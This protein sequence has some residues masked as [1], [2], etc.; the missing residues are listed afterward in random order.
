MEQRRAS[1]TTADLGLDEFTSA[2]LHTSQAFSHE[3]EG[4]LGDSPEAIAHDAAII[5][6]IAAGLCD[7]H[8]ERSKSTEKPVPKPVVRDS[9]HEEA[10]SSQQRAES[11]GGTPELGSG[12]AGRPENGQKGAGNSGGKKKNKKKARKSI[13]IENIT[14]RGIG[15]SGGATAAPEDPSVLAPAE[16]N[17]DADTEQ[18]PTDNTAPAAQAGAGEQKQEEE[19][20]KSPLPLEVPL[21]SFPELMRGLEMSTTDPEQLEKMDTEAEHHTPSEHEAEEE[22]DFQDVGSG[23][24]SVGSVRSARGRRLGSNRPS[25]ELEGNWAGFPSRNSGE[26]HLG[27]AMTRQSP[28]WVLLLSK[29]RLVGMALW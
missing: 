11:G 10:A 19:A 3:L 22:E 25:L 17:T 21:P 28:T 1:S 13:G 26:D 24:E 5:A 23:T 9:Q 20:P 4:D 29:L 27:N 7:R 18:P 8:S 2:F 16:A 6:D 15:I 12:Q 14:A